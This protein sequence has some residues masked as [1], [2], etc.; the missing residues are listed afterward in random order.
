MAGFSPATA[1]SI[2][3]AVAPP[4]NPFKTSNSVGPVAAAIFNEKNRQITF[5]PTHLV[6]N[7]NNAK[8]RAEGEGRKIDLVQAMVEGSTPGHMVHE[9]FHQQTVTPDRQ[10]V[11]ADPDFQGLL[12]LMQNRMADATPEQRREVFREY[13]GSDPINRLG[14]VADPRAGLIGEVTEAE[15]LATVFEGAFGL[16]RSANQAPDVD[17]KSLL[18]SRDERLPGTR[19]AFNFLVRRFP[20]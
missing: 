13:Y 8:A 15:M 16:A 4:T 3:T 2:F 12:N 11:G 6:V 17:I 19:E 1:D 20:R 18:D 5:S 7:A 9:L 10:I 14:R